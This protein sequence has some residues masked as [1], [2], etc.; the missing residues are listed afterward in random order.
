M[1]ERAIVC[2]SLR[3]ARHDLTVGEGG[4]GAELVPSPAIRRLY[5]YMYHPFDL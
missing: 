4:V 5:M 2:S 3:P 1:G